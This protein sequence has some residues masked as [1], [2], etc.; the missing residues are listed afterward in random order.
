LSLP[1]FLLLVVELYVLALGCS[2]L[3]SALYVKFRDVRH[4][5]EVGLQILFYSSP[6]IY[7]LN[8]VPPSVRPWL[9]LSPISQIIQDA[10]WLLIT[11]QTVTATGAMHL[12]W[13]LVPYLLPLLILWMG[14]SYFNRTAAAFAEEI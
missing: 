2:L 14:Y 11:P 8:I 3:L 12:P 9:T 10:R 7:P 5:W 13:V 1:L 6:I 4:I